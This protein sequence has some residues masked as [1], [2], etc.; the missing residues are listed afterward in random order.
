MNNFHEAQKIIDFFTAKAE[1]TESQE[2]VYAIQY[3][4]LKMV[5]HRCNCILDTLKSYDLEVINE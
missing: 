5:E 2:A 1:Q 3:K 4:N